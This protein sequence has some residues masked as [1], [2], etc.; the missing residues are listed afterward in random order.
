[1]KNIKVCCYYKLNDLKCVHRFALFS[2]YLL[3][4]FQTVFLFHRSGKCTESLG[5]AQNAWWGKKKSQLS[6]R[7]FSI[8][9][10]NCLWFFFFSFLYL[11]GIRKQL[12]KP[13]LIKKEV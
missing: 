1:M 13:L 2:Y 10:K 5:S 4:F 3:L 9:V 6:S 8:L 7:A 11:K 12:K